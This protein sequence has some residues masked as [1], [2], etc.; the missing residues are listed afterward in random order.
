MVVG[1]HDGLRG[2]GLREA[3]RVRL[4]VR[5]VLRA[6]VRDEVRAL[7]DQRAALRVRAREGRRPERAAQEDLAVSE[8]Y[9]T[10]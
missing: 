1:V 7:V 6:G 8:R 4:A 5:V 10:C 3:H 9:V 2:V